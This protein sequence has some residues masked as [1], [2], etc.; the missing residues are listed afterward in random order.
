M[1]RVD[2]WSM[3]WNRKSRCSAHSIP[4]VASFAV[5]GANRVIDRSNRPQTRPARR[6]FWSAAGAN[7][8]ICIRH[9]PCPALQ[10]GPQLLLEPIEQ[11]AVAY[12]GRVRRASVLEGHETPVR[13]HDRVRRLAALV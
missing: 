1:T 13:C 10:E 4:P 2:P 9:H 12:T 7:A 8:R 11:D 6:V 5:S 3:L